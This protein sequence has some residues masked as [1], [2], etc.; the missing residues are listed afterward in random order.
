M[1]DDDLATML[2]D[3]GTGGRIGTHYD[4]CH[5]SHPRCAVEALVAEVRRLRAERDN[6]WASNV[7]YRGEVNR[8]ELEAMARAQ[9]EGGE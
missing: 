8:M 3:C 6:L 4:G 2:R 1:T 7:I 9:P 5:R